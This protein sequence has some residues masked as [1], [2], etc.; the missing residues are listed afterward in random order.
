MTATITTQDEKAR[1]EEGPGTQTRSDSSGVQGITPPQDCILRGTEQERV[2]EGQE[3]THDLDAK[4]EL[5]QS[6]FHCDEGMAPPT[7]GG[8]LAMDVGSTVFQ[9][10]FLSWPES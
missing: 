3:W 6:V 4:P 2:G 10:D 1:E 9:T 7:S 5:N 8:V